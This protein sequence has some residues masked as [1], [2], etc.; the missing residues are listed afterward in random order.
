[1]KKI[2]L[3]LFTLIIFT[4]CSKEN[5]VEHEQLPCDLIDLSEE[6]DPVCGCDGT[7]YKNAGYA[8]CIGGITKYREG[9]CK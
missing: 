2:G 9:E 1:M 4:Q 3:S 8:Q 7:T 5:C 6:Y